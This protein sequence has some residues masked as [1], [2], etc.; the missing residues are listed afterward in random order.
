MSWKEEL[1]LRDIEDA[2]RIDITCKKCGY[3]WHEKPEQ[4]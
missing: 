3:S 2:T 4:A 1:K